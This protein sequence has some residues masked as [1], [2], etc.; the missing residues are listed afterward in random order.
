MLNYINIDPTDNIIR[1][2]EQIFVDEDIILEGF[3]PNL[4]IRADGTRDSGINFGD[5]DATGDARIFYDA[6]LDILKMGT[7]VSSV[8]ASAINMNSDDKVGFNIDDFTS[9]DELDAQV[10]IRANSGNLTT[11]AH[12][13]LYENNNAGF[14][15]IHFPNFAING[16][17]QV[18]ASAEGSATSP[19]LKHFTHSDDG[20]SAAEEE[21]LTINGSDTRVGVGDDEP[22]FTLSIDFP[23]GAP[24][25][26]G[27]G[28]LSLENT[29]N[30]DSWTMYTSSTSDSL[31][32]LL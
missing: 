30:N 3:S 20:T 4:N 19:G 28:A 32:F 16:Y 2:N 25:T 11:P 26:G 1:F 13:E 18:G 5:N 15:N 12:L 6:S 10:T 31:R 21:I 7:G 17:W 14:P 29:A 8:V 22:E 9:G 27:D 23:A 24:S